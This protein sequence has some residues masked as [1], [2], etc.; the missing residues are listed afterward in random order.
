MVD[1]VCDLL[2]RHVGASVFNGFHPKAVA[3]V[4][5][6][7]IVTLYYDDDIEVV[8]RNAKEHWERLM[9]AEKH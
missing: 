7:Q 4:D 1:P 3:G 8:R 9:K 6:P 2:R 5:G